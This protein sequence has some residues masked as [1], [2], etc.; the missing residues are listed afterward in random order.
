MA[1]EDLRV[2]ARGAPAWRPSGS[3]YIATY[4]AF[5]TSTTEPTVVAY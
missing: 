4:P 1:S 2:G 3:H 5:F